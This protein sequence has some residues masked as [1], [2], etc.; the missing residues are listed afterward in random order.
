MGKK[1][2]SDGHTSMGLHSNVSKDT[3][4]AMRKERSHLDTMINKY[5]AFKRVRMLC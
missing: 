3:L 1:K 4:K 5:D 2:K